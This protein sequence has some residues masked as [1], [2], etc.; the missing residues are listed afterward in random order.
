MTDQ[1]LNDILEIMDL[2]T[3]KIY[4]TGILPFFILSLLTYF[5]LT[6]P[7]KNRISNKL[8]AF[9]LILNT[10]E[11]SGNFTPIFLGSNNKLIV[12]SNSLF[13]LQFPVF[14]LYVQ[15]I[16]YSDF[17]LKSKHLFH[18]IPFIT[19]NI[20][21]LPNFYLADPSELIYLIG[22]YKILLEIKLNYILLHLTII[23]YLVVIFKLLSNFRK[24]YF[25]NYSNNEISIYKWL[26][27]LTIVLSIE[28]LAALLKNI[29]DF[30]NMNKSYEI[31]LILMGLIVLLITSWYVIKALK[32]PEI[33][34]GIPSSLQKTKPLEAIRIIEKNA[35]IFSQLEVYME[36]NE[37]FL[38]SNLTLEKLA[39]SFNI[40][41]KELSVLINYKKGSHFF[42]FINEYRIKKAKKILSDPKKNDKTILEV[43]YEVGF[44]SKSSFNT[45]FKKH[46][47]LT[48]TEFKKANS[49]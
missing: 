44:N 3:F 19:G 42:D 34:I 7:S 27:Q 39:F 17:Y 18:A 28:Q 21:L 9:F 6:S 37:P 26:F 13:Y 30:L 33:F 25:E 11:I 32:Y 48:P 36:K 49:L 24:S 22:N 2:D 4:I 29:S 38:D 23:C 12:F 1:I 43:L 41:P 8:F 31:L 47:N 15:S 35:N 16:C 5:L 20:I 14:Y 10:I 46:T 40:K 45:A